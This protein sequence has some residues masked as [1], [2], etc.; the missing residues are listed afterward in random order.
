[1][2][3]LILA[4]SIVVSCQLHA[5]QSLSK[6]EQKI[7]DLVNARIPQNLELL[8]NLV[9]TNSGTLNIS[10]VKQVGAQLRSEFDKIGFTTE[11]INLPDSLKRAG[12]LG[13]Y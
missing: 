13:A 8:K 12:H 10:G 2:R 3:K 11:W 1:M 5:Q 6:Q 4:L 9:N 7:I